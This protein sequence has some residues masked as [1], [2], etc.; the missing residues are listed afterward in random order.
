MA[1]PIKVRGLGTK[2]HDVHEYTVILMYIPGNS[3]KVALINHKI[4]IVDELSAKALIGIDIM[5]PEAIDTG[6]DLVIIESCD[7]LQVPVSMITKSPR[8][9]T[10]IVS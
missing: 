9:N 4:H 8:T 2:K 7:S 3:N 5:K 1:S 10:T 6:K